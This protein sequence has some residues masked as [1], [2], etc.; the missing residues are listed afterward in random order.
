MS[1]N[2]KYYYLKLKDSFF[3]SEEMKILESQVNGIEYQNLYLKMCLLSI[4]SGGEL[5]F[6]EHIPY[7]LKMISTVLRVN[8]D[9][10]KTGI[11]IFIKLG[12]I[13]KVESGVIFMSDIQS[14]I[15]RG[16]TE[17]ER[18]AE[19]RKKIYR[20]IVPR[21]SEK[22]PPELELELELDKELEGED[23]CEEPDF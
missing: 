23:K 2:K 6:K 19:Y 1:D 15:G 7:D 22:C 17:A 13:V 14:L 21:M 11:E 20:D 5:I 9:T 10:V 18:K 3:D 12:L 8:I 4:K 16:S